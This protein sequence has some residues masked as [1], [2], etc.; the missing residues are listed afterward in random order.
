MV[1]SGYMEFTSEHTTSNPA[2]TAG[3]YLTP[4]RRIVSTTP[5]A[6]PRDLI[7]RACVVANGVIVGFGAESY[8]L[9]VDALASLIEGAA[10]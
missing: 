9:A 7:T 1:F 10:A 2:L 3:G 5:S 8:V 4:R 6:S